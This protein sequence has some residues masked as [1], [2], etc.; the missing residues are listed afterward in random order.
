MKKNNIK[1]LS[2]HKETL[3]QLTTEE[4]G[5]V[6]G[7]KD[8]TSASNNAGPCCVFCIFISWS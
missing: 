2:L 1:K 3:R 4:L 6:A 8:W 7:G 5:Q